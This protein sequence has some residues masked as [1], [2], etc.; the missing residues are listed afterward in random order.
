LINN[1]YAD[2]LGIDLIGEEGIS[3]YFKIGFQKYINI[4][5]IA[6]SERTK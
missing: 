2:A 3:D 1:E 5:E 6:P 4:F